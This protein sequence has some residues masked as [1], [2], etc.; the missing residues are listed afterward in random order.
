MTPLNVDALQVYLCPT[1]TCRDVV[2]AFGLTESDLPRVV[3]DDTA[4][5]KKYVMPSKSLSA[6]EVEFFIRDSIQS[7]SQ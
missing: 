3:I 7:C 4:G 5:G 2:G 1:D 6:T